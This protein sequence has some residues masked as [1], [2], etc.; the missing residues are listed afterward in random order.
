MNYKSSR[1]TKI[2][3]IGLFCRKTPY[4]SLEEAQ[5]MIRYI[6]E[7]RVTREIRAYK[8]SICG[9][10]HLTSRKEDGEK[11]GGGD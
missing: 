1:K 5:D 9:F 8:C 4:N 10:W 6:N 3:P 11:G 7:T 2:E